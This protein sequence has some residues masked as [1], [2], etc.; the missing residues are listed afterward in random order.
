MTAYSYIL[1]N[2]T[3]TQMTLQVTPKHYL[4]VSNLSWQ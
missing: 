1:K 4:N 2:K 3:G